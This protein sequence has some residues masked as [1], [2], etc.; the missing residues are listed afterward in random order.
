[1]ALRKFIFLCLYFVLS[2]SGILTAKIEYL[3]PQIVAVWPHDTK[4]FTQG[5]VLH[6]N[7]L[8]ESSGLYGK[9]NLK[10]I[11][12]LTGNVLKTVNVPSLFFAEGLALINNQLI[13]LTWR[14]QIAFVYDR[15]TLNQIKTFSY[16]GQGWG[17]CSDGQV[18][19]MSDGTDKIVQRHPQTFASLKAY[20][21]M[22][23]SQKIKG[24]NALTCVGQEI[25]ANI[26]P[27]NWIV[28]FDKST[29]TV[30][31]LIHASGLLTAKEYQATG[32]E[33]VLNGITYHP[34]RQT[35][36]LTGKYWP[37]L[38]EVRFVPE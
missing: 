10:E 34:E 33:G 2:Q 17:L 27:T 19:Y 25:Y 30:T 5:L 15:E 22:N 32:R 31:G 29:G 36:F 16:E 35:F 18:L 20:Q 14:E 21:I 12:L 4:A 3:V 11:N 37:W 6:Q 1:M 7:L 8:Y 23:G 9:S 26:W 38:F 13:Q 28:R 24:L